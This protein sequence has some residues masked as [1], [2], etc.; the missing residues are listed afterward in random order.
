MRAAGESVNATEYRV[1]NTAA[2]PSNRAW[3]F[4]GEE[5][6]YEKGENF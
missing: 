1:K 3:I 6:E 2:R 4:E 5:M